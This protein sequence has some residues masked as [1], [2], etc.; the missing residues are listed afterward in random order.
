MF[1]N[2]DISYQTFIGLSKLLGG[3]GGGTVWYGAD[4]YFFVFSKVSRRCAVLSLSAYLHFAGTIYYDNKLSTVFKTV[5]KVARL[6]MF[7]H[8]I[9][10][11]HVL[12]RKYMH[13]ETLALLTKHYVF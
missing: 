12:T 4:W 1:V 10:L 7:P 8:A 13:A 6:Y 2:Y 3:G 11:F 9:V 5:F